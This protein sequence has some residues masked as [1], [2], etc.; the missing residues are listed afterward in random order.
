MGHLKTVNGYVSNLIPATKERTT[1]M[2]MEEEEEEEEE[3]KKPVAT[4]VIP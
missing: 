4:G 3:E 2:M 1:D